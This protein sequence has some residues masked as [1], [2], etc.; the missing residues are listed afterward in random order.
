MPQLAALS[1]MQF[2][3]DSFITSRMILTVPEQYPLG[4]Q[5]KVC[6]NLYILSVNVSSAAMA[7]CITVTFL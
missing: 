1:I 5:Y 3:F 6:R 7:N 4:N 2:S